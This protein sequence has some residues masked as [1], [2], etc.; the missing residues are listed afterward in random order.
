MTDESKALIGIYHGMTACK[1]NTFGVPS[2]PV[3]YWL[4]VHVICVL[5]VILCRNCCG[6][7]DVCMR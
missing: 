5:L 6:C 3:R 2:H 7:V 1:K 4:A